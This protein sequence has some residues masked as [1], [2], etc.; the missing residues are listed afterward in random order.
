MGFFRPLVRVSVSELC[1][2]S[3]TRSIDRYWRHPRLFTRFTMYRMRCVR[4]HRCCAARSRTRPTMT[5]TMTTTIRML[6]PATMTARKRTRVSRFNR[7]VV[8]FNCHENGPRSTTDEE[9]FV[10]IRS[11]HGVPLKL[12]SHLQARRRRRT[13]SPTQRT[14][15]CNS[16]TVKAIRYYDL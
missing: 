8:C 10:L 7:H 6:S 12:V 5:T 1:Y 15:M 13:K 11:H 3:T 14:A 16:R 4:V 2:Y 9:R